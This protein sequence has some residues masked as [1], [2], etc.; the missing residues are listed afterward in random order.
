MCDRMCCWCWRVIDVGDRGANL[1]A[2]RSCLRERLMCCGLE[3]EC[4]VGWMVI[5]WK[6]GSEW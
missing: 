6:N 5:L 2:R 1:R 4:E 3:I